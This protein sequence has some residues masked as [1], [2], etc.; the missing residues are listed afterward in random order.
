MV[1]T[2]NES[3]ATVAERHEVFRDVVR[4]ITVHVMDREKVS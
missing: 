1:V 2:M 3:V 4:G